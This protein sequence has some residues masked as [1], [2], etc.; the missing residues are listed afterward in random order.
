MRVFLLTICIFAIYTNSFSQ[1]VGIGTNTPNPNSALEISDSTRG[2]IIPRMDSTKRKLI[3]NIVGML[4]YDSSYKSFWYNNGS[5]WF[6]ISPQTSTSQNNVSLGIDG[7]GNTFAIVTICTQQWTQKN[8]N[9]D[10][11]RNG[12]SIP[13]VSNSSA[14]FALTTGAWCYYNNDPATAA[15]FGRLYNWYAVTDSRGLAPTGWHIPSQ[16]EWLTLTQNCLVSDQGLKMKTTG[17]SIWT[18]NPGAT[19]SSGF[20][21]VPGGF[22]GDTGS[23]FDLNNAGYFWSTTQDPGNA[24]AGIYLVL[25]GPGN[26]VSLGA[27]DKRSGLSVRCIKD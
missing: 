16:A 5:G 2:I 1:N 17:T 27:T 10:T 15:V 13:Q 14:W 22:R 11:Y 8:L 7:N 4:V 20:S 24:G 3:P 26:G 18:S 21:A 6:S 12:Q 19:N 23:F 9:V 25:T